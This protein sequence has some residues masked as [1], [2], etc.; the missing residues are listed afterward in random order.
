VSHVHT[1]LSVEGGTYH[2]WFGRWWPNGVHFWI[3]PFGLHLFWPEVWKSRPD[4][5][6]HW[7]EL[8]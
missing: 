4:F 7:R 8:V 3:G 2:R 5:C 6:R 1:C